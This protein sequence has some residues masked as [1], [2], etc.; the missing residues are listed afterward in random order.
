LIGG[1]IGAVLARL[2]SGQLMESVF[3]MFGVQNIE[4]D[5]SFLAFAK[6]IIL[7]II[8]YMVFGYLSSRKVKKVSARELI[9]E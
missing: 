2:Y 5:Y 4:L 6:P 9:S 3:S 7:F 1:I 8:L